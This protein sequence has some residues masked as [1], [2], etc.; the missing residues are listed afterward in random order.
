HVS[1][2]ITK[3]RQFSTSPT[4]QILHSRKYRYGAWY[5][6]KNLWQHSLKTEELQD[7]KILQAERED[8]TRKREEQMNARLAPLH[9]I[10]A[11]KE[12]LVEKNVRRLPKLITDVEQ[13]RRDNPR[14]LADS[15]TELQTKK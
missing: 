10:D 1:S 12:Y 14:D 11:F 5:L 4:N 2:S 15:T 8:P 7:P 3:S 6:P 13:Y 9:G